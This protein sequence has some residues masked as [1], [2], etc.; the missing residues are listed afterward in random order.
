LSWANRNRLCFMYATD[1]R[2]PPTSTAL[3]SA[4]H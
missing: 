4:T 3:V 2:V 1:K